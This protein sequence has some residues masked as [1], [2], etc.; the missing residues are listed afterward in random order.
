MKVIPAID[1]MGGRCVRLYMGDF[2]RETRYS[3]DPLEVALRWQEAGATML[4]LVDLDGAKSGEPRH[5]GLVARICEALRVPV[6]V[7]GGMRS[8]AAIESTLAAGAYRV[9]LGTAALEDPALLAEAL[10]RWGTSIVVSLDARDGMLAT[11][12][13]LDTGK[14]AAVDVASQLV[15]AGV[16]C[17]V[18]TDISRDGT[19]QG[20]DLG[21]IRAMRQAAGAGVELIA[22]GGVGSEAD[23]VRLR[24]CGADGAI[25]GKALYDKTIDPAVLGNA[26][27]GIR[28]SE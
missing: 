26:E 20:P 17:L 25:V 4:H 18:Y 27:C 5:A 28:N 9:I 12:G 3:D 7:G 15:K 19:L 1:L 2:S 23:L 21:G 14:R 11:R 6:Q 24:E 16:S 22:S 8:L 10:R 13:W